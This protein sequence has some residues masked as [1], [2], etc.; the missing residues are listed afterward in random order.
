MA[1]SLEF[2][3]KPMLATFRS[4]NDRRFSWLRNVFLNFLH[5]LLNSAEQHQGNFKK[6]TDQKMFTS[7]Q[8]YEGLK[9]SVNVINKT[10]QFIL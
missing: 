1:Q 6:D 3:R 8:T 2:E 10:I 5:N 4:V 7:W 9:I